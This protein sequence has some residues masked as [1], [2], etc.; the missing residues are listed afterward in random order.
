MRVG[1]RRRL[2]L[3]AR[4]VLAG[5][6]VGVIYGSLLGLAY[7]GAPLIGGLIGAV[8]G[9]TISSVVGLMEIFV[10]R[11]RLGRRLERAPLLV[12]V[13]VK[14]S[15]YG[16]VIAVV[17]ARGLGMIVLGLRD[18]APLSS[19]YG[20]QSVVFSFVFTLAFIFVL[21]VSRIVGGAPCGTSRWA[22]IIARARRSGSS[23][24]WTSP[25]RPASPRAWVRPRCTGS[26]TGCSGYRPI[27]ST[28]IEA[29]S[30]NTSETR[31]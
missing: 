17:E 6:L 7:R 21:Q 1:N 22:G 29:R 25:G 27:R 30:I 8:H 9:S 14:G 13:A 16:A 23:S 10:T 19:P 3:L 20:P 18:P 31:W 4:V 15:V 11:T 26:S 24:S 12:T 5:T 28:I 2:W